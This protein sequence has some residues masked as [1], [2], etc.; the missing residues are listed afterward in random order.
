MGDVAMRCWSAQFPSGSAMAF[1]A[2]SIV[3]VHGASKDAIMAYG[4][5]GDHFD[6]VERTED[7]TRI[8]LR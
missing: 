2:A 3:I 1:P 7:D 8:P 6:P 5:V 4:L